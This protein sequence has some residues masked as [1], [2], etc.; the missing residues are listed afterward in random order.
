MIAVHWHEGMFLRSHHFQAAQRWWAQLVS[1]NSKWDH[2]YNWGLR[3]VELDEDALA[4]Y[5]CVLRS[6][7][8]RL[9][10]GTVVAVSPGE[11]VAPLSLQNSDFDQG[12]IFLFVHVPPFD[13]SRPNA[14]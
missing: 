13:L 8:A 14:P 11:T 3:S 1:T 9:R 10:D 7:E 12:K 4:N 5:R 6:L 2:Y